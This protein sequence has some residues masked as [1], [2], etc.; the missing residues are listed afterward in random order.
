MQKNRSAHPLFECC[1]IFVLV[2][3]SINRININNIYAG[4]CKMNRMLEYTD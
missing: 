4:F 1:L 2:R 3:H